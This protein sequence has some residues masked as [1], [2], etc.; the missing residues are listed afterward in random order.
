MVDLLRDHILFIDK[1][2]ITLVKTGQSTL[3]LLRAT[4]YLRCFP[5]SELYQIYFFPYPALQW[6]HIWSSSKQVR[7]GPTRFSSVYL[8]LMYYNV[9]NQNYNNSVNLILTK[10]RK[11]P[12]IIV[13]SVGTVDECS[14]SQV[15][16]MVLKSQLIKIF[17]TLLILNVIT[18]PY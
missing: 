9:T 4:L 1:H 15:G 12:I 6:S 10:E 16:L 13:S 5:M 2:L 7:I 3:K 11:H 8:N 14:P 18:K 17:W